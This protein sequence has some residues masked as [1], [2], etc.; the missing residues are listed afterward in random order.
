MV[1][2]VFKLDTGAEVSAVT[3]ETYTN[4]GIKLSKPQ[5]GQTPLQVTG[6]FQGKLEYKGKGTFQS[7]PLKEKPTWAPCYYSL[8]PGC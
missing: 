6:Q 3:Q 1:N 2:T 7:K 5:N 4:L 8:E